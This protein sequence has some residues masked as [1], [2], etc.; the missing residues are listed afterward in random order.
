MEQRRCACKGVRSCL[1]CERPEEAAARVRDTTTSF[2]Q[3]HRC[4][5][6]LRQGVV[7]PDLEAKPLFV[8][9]T[10]DCGPEEKIIRA[11]WRGKEAVELDNVYD[12]AVFEGVTVVKEFVSFEEEREIVSE[13]DANR[14]A[15]SQSGRRKQ[16][17]I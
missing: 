2:Y 7:Q 8:C 16:V 9:K 4:G 12:S 10:G 17:H 14:W 3:C 5:N 11:R 1:I 15:E 6:I 13:I